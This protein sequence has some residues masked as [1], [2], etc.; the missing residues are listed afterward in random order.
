[1]LRVLLGIV[2]T[3]AILAFILIALHWPF[4]EAA[5]I[6]SLQQASSSKVEVGKFRSTYFP[7][8]GCVA[9]GVI[10][11]RELNANTPP[12]VTVQRLTIQGSYLGLV[13]KHVPRIRT[14]GMTIFIPSQSGH[15][16]FRSS[17]DVTIDEWIA[18]D[19]GLEFGSRIPGKPPL[20]F[21]IHQCR[22]YGV[23]GVSPV[24]FRVKLTNPEPPGEITAHGNIGPWRVGDATQTP[25]S[26]EYLF[27]HANLGV[28]GGI[29]GLLSSSGKFDGTLGR[30]KV[31]GTT[32]TP[33]F[34]VT[35]SSHRVDLK[36]QFNA[37]VNAKTGDVELAQVDA[38][39]WK[40]SVIS[41]GRVARKG[42]TRVTELDMRSREGRIEDLLDLVITDSKP[43]ITGVTSFRGHVVLPAG[44][45][46]FLK[47]IALQGEFGVGAGN[48]TKPETQEDVNK[49]SAEARAQDDQ[50]AATVLS[51]LKGHVVL[52]GGVAQFSYLSFTIP[53]AFAIMQGTYD[54]ISEKIN[55]HGVL[56]LDSSLSHTAHGPK[57]LLLKALQPFFKRKSKG[58]KIAVKITGTY[59]HPSFGLDLT[60]QKEDA[61]TK[62]LRRL[63][64]KPTK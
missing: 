55:L 56:R 44:N 8:P 29:A 15:E 35:D 17:S 16:K 49:L 26:G 4:T 47:K 34:K 60:G 63:Y 42:S 50:N 22:L 21:A 59:D 10:F 23:G 39:F 43:P 13:T 64:Q 1:M 58:S 37:F 5:V 54:V 18:D 31:E 61:T 38:H 46:P 41:S 11:R 19:A 25:V 20:K 62:R 9:A 3:G 52:K 53:G 51:D 24:R 45:G 32:D 36:S 6:K 48:F 57:A 33:E 2:S 12:L 14:E 30:I 7:H 40:T 27:E 28:F